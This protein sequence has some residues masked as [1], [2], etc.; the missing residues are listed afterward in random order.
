MESLRGY[1]LVCLRIIAPQ[2]P[3]AGTDDTRWAEVDVQALAELP[4]RLLQVMPTLRY[5]A[6]APK[7]STLD[8]YAWYED[9]YDPAC[10]EY[11]WYR[12]VEDASGDRKLEGITTSDGERVRRFLLDADLEAIT[13]IDGGHSHGCLFLRNC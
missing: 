7:R 8:E 4:D 10:A 9:G 3:V 12:A 11:K 13:N 6:W 2:P 5:V 1:S